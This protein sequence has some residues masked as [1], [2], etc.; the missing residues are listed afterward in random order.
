[1]L[2]AEWQYGW[3]RTLELGDDELGELPEGDGAGPL[4]ELPLE[5]SA[6]LPGLSDGKVLRVFVEANRQRRPAGAGI[7]L[8]N[9]C[10]DDDDAC[11]K[12]RFTT[13]VWYDR[14]FGVPF[15]RKPDELEKPAAA[16]GK[17]TD[18]LARPV[19]GQ[20]LLLTAAGGRRVITITDERGE[21]R[22]DE[23]PGGEATLMPVGKNPS[24]LAKGT[25][26][27]RL[28]LGTSETKVPV[29]YVNKL[30]E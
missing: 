2:I 25:E 7:K 4:L 22:F 1:V 8:G 3:D 13:E 20:R 6:P 18:R 28:L 19:G 30:W 15:L 5:L 14:V 21:Y 29:T 17:V 10:G 16:V 26:L 23:L 27:R 9:G 11:E 12:L 24:N